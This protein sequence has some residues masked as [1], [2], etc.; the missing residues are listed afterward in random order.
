MSAPVTSLM[1][2]LIPGVEL[3]EGEPYVSVRKD[4]DAIRIVA[5]LLSSGQLSL[6]GP[7]D[8]V[9]EVEAGAVGDTA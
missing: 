4:R 7:R 1:G 3:A 2:E 8:W 9:A 5:D 6:E